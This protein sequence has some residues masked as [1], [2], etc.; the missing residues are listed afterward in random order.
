MLSSRFPGPSLLD[1]HVLDNPG[2][3]ILVF[4]EPM[5]HM[6]AH[7]DIVAQCQTLWSPSAAAHGCSGNSAVRTELEASGVT[8]LASAPF[9][10]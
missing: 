6:Q 9:P 7:M 2:N 3:A 5:S 8:T 1:S 10:G 4:G